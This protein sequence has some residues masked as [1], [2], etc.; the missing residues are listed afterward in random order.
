MK[1][2][3][4]PRMVL[5]NSRHAAEAFLEDVELMRDIMDRRERTGA[6]VRALSVSLR[7]LLVD[8]DIHVVAGPRVGK[9]SLVIPDNKPIYKRADMKGVAMWISGGAPIFNVMMRGAVVVA[10]S[11]TFEQDNLD[12]R[13]PVKL[14]GF[15]NQRVIYFRGI[16]IN[17]REV[18]KF[19]ANKAGGAHAGPP[20]NHAEETLTYL[21][22][23]VK[24]YI[25]ED[26]I[27]AFLIDDKAVLNGVAKVEYLPNNMHPAFMEVLAAAYF[28][29]ESPDILALHA[30]VRA[31][32]GL[33]PKLI[34]NKTAGAPAAPGPP[35]DGGQALSD[36]PAP[37]AHRL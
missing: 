21:S 7:R 6:D 35:L 34:A 14:D 18:I 30:A 31:E 5:I 36:P 26:D 27:P 20:Q 22:Y 15:L 16:W 11:V 24:H 13:V 28:L 10:S 2:P 12:A 23:A 17:R 32:L 9:I 1:A 25:M 4:D 8:S 33:P 37:D 19:V 29:L 3:P